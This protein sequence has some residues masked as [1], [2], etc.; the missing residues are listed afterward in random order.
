MTAFI[1]EVTYN[2]RPRLPKYF[3]PYN[4]AEEAFTAAK[5]RWPGIDRTK[6]VWRCTH[7]WVDRVGFTNVVAKNDDKVYSFT[8]LPLGELT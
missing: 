4:S 2:V 7:P 8:V 3:G 6:G 1:I 5:Y